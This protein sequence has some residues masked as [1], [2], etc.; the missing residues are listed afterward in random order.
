MEKYLTGKKYINSKANVFTF[1]IK[2][3]QI[4]EYSA[5]VIFLLHTLEM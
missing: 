2:I 3:Q 4:G 1:C 5:S